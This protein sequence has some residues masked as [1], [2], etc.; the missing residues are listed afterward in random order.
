M[1]L[2]E[3]DLFSGVSGTAKASAR[4][5]KRKK[6]FDD[7]LSLSDLPPLTPEQEQ[8]LI[9]R[10]LGGGVSGLQ[11]LGETLD[12]PRRALYGALAGSR[13]ALNIVPFSDTIGL[14]DPAE[15]ITGRDA[16]EAAGILGKNTDGLDFGDVAGFLFELPTDPLNAVSFGAKSAVGGAIKAGTSAASKLDDIAKGA[17][18][19]ARIT[20]PDIGIPFT[21]IKTNP[22]TLELFGKPLEWTGDSAAKFYDKLNY[23]GYSPVPYVRKV[24]S[25]NENIVNAPVGYQKD[26]DLKTDAVQSATEASSGDIMELFRL[27]DQAR[28]S[29]EQL[30]TDQIIGTDPIQ[31]RTAK[32]K[33]VSNIAA[34]DPEFKSVVDNR[35]K[36]FNLSDD[37]GNLAPS[38]TAA[39]A[40]ESLASLYDEAMDIKNGYGKIGEKLGNELVRLREE[41][42]QGAANAPAGEQGWWNDLLADLSETKTP[43]LP[44]Y[45]ELLKG[46]GYSDSL[47][48]FTATTKA[49]DEFVGFVRKKYD[50]FEGKMRELGIDMG[51]YENPFVAY[52]HRSATKQYAKD[53]SMIDASRSGIVGKM[54][55]SVVNAVAKQLAGLRRDKIKAQQWVESLDQDTLDALKT[56][57]IPAKNH[58]AYPLYEA[59]KKAGVNWNDALDFAQSKRAAERET[60][61]GMRDTVFS[62]AE[63]YLGPNWHSVIRNAARS[64]QGNFDATKI[65]KL[66]EIIQS[67]AFKRGME[68][69]T[70]STFAQE[71]FDQ[72]SHPNPIGRYAPRKLADKTLIDEA[73]EAARKNQDARDAARVNP[74]DDFNPASFDAAAV[75][76]SGVKFSTEL[77]AEF[78]K[79]NGVPWNGDFNANMRKA[80]AEHPDQD[81]AALAQRGDIDDETFAAILKDTAD[82]KGYTTN[83]KDVNTPDDLLEY[84][85]MHDPAVKNAGGY[86]QQEIN[87]LAKWFMDLPDGVRETGFFDRDVVM[88]I[89]DYYQQANR[90][91]AQASILRSFFK[92]TRFVGPLGKDG[93]DLSIYDTWKGAGMTD[94]GLLTL[95]AERRG[96]DYKTIVHQRRLMKRTPTSKGYTTKLVPLECPAA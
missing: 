44:Y 54:K 22:R 16:L 9:S 61:Q 1:A 45:A 21:K 78:L 81:F 14:T 29:T 17:T 57:R 60:L 96:Q 65:P 36:P 79:R 25:G 10:A 77:V 2:F 94:E 18:S 24:F 89:A 53:A 12:K 58:Y 52:S 85:H 80:I 48:S 62:T 63:E 5:K 75:P 76:K 92:D 15:T 37:F 87:D 88:D 69:V 13:E 90:K 49:Y 3:N 82:A 35:L 51:R 46:H 83:M 34:V 23:G 41:I 33:V 31:M 56:E 38:V 70:D 95:M 50:E 43:G 64:L 73:V 86:S 67:I 19:I 55:R 68:G 7:E 84:M 59:A 30:R 72:L 40:E 66:D 32:A 42:A 26:I 4:S 93:N 28:K 27:K 6:A 39:K 91:I 74:L 71:I 20:T 8:G 47:D 11:W